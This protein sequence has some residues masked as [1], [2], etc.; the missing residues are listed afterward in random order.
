MHILVWLYWWLDSTHWLSHNSDAL[1]AASKCPKHSDVLPGVTWSLWAHVLLFFNHF[2][3]I[4]SCF[5]S[6]LYLR[7]VP[8]CKSSFCS[9]LIV[10][11]ATKDVK[12]MITHSHDDESDDDFWTSVLV[13]FCCCG[14]KR[15]LR[16]RW[17]SAVQ[18]EACLAADLIGQL[19]IRTRCR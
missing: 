8:M 1:K 16:W 2:V 5:C 18:S 11:F 9:N 19:S 17:S 14:F 4:W 3:F 13:R 15:L 12:L 6:C 7:V 10:G